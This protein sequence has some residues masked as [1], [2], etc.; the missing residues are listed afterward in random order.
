MTRLHRYDIGDYV[1]QDDRTTA[2]DQF[3]NVHDYQRWARNWNALLARRLRQ[4]VFATARGAAYWAVEPVTANSLGDTLGP[5]IVPVPR[6][7]RTMTLYMRAT[8]VDADADVFFYPASIGAIGGSVPGVAD[9]DYR[10]QATGTSAADYSCTVRVDES[11]RNAGYGLFTLGYI[12]EI[13]IAEGVKQTLGI[14]DAGVNWVTVDASPQIFGRVLTFQ[15][16]PT[17]GKQIGVYVNE[18]T[19]DAT[20]G[21]RITVAR[22][23]QEVPTVSDT[24]ETYEV[25]FVNVSGFSLYPDRVASFTSDDPEL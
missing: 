3:L 4:P 12:S 21:Y 18:V 8:C 16:N 20:T 15:S 22:P 2:V 24:V 7:C 10:I 1:A 14:L 19:I 11:A 17:I 13:D 23:W 5:F 9:S 25:G 6:H